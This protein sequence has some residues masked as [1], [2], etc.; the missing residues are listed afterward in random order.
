MV[1]F[2]LWY[3]KNT[4]LT[5]TTYIDVYWAGSGDDRKSTSGNAFFLGD[6]LVPWLSKKQSSISLSTVEGNYIATTYCCTQ[7]LWMKE[8][9]DNVNI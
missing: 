4:N 9:L 8:A 5:F 7:F 2:V 6:Y 3:P 1:C